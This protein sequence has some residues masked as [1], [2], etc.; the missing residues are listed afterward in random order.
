MELEITDRLNI[1]GTEITFLGDGLAVLAARTAAE[2]KLENNVEI[3]KQLEEEASELNKFANWITLFGD[4]ISA[5]AA[6]MEAKE[7][8][9]EISTDKTKLKAT[10]LNVLSSWLIVLGDA[11]AVQ[12]EALEEST[13]E[14]TANT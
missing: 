3:K 2:Q 14:D 1:L 7:S 13:N 10:N 5:L 11:L 12:A 9:R 8:I 4:F 6:D